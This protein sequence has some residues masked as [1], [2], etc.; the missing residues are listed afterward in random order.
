VQVSA[1]VHIKLLKYPKRKRKRNMINVNAR[2][3]FK[4]C[5]D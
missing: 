3:V 5:I 4:N 1:G 2:C